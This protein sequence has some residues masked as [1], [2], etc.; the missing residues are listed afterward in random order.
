MN[1]KFDIHFFL[2]IAAV[3][4]LAGA[5]SIQFLE[6]GSEYEYLSGSMAPLVR[7]S[8]GASDINEALKLN[9]EIDKLEKELRALDLE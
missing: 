4:G 1:F 9:A 8:R 7:N 6:A 2:A 5:L 3:F